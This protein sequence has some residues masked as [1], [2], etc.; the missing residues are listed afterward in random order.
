MKRLAL[1]LGLLLLLLLGVALVRTL[2][3]PSRQLAVAAAEPV[4]VNLE[5]VADALSAG[6]TFA[7]LSDAEGSA[8]HAEAFAGFTALL[9]A[10]YP[11]VHRAL[12]RETLTGGSLLYTWTGRDA[13]APPRLLAAHSDV[14]P[15]EPG[16]EAK[17][18]QPPFSGARSGGY[19]WGRGAI[20]DKAALFAILEAV[21]ALLETGFTPE[22]SVLLAFGH[23]EEIGGEAGARAIATRLRERNVTLASVIDEG[24]VVAEGI[25]DLVPN[26]VAVVGVAE[27]GS[28]TLHLDVELEGGHS[29]TPPPQSSV[30]VLAAAVAALEAHPMPRRLGATTR[31]FL[32]FLAPE[33]PFPLRFVMANLWLTRPALL[34]TFEADSQLNAMVRTSTA[35]TVFHAGVKGNVLPRSARAT[36]N[37]R[38]LPGDTVDDVL[39]HVRRTIDDPRIELT[40]DET[41]R[42]RNPSPVSPTDSPAF[43]ALQRTITAQFPD[44]IVVPYLVLGGTDARH[45]VELTPNVYRFGPFR[46]GRDTSKR[47]HGTNERISLENLESAVRFYRAYLMLSESD[48]EP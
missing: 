6:I 32:G 47:L 23:D 37:F 11:R 9:E 16:T 1:A 17:W 35:A 5:R 2:T 13:Q 24:G 39:E 7:T 18:E 44:A 43:R 14:V 34:T 38:I 26:P 42:P 48:G 46:M 22:T 20:D 41:S 36:V 27:K 40:P 10:R 3:L 31:G 30:G 4:P 29:S 12:S 21:E 8:R 28:L 45:Y 15:I 19:I 25:V 33:L